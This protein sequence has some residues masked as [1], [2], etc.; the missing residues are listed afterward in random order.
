MIGTLIEKA[1]PLSNISGLRPIQSANS[2][3]NRVEK[4]LPRSTA[5]TMI[6]IW[7]RFR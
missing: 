5:A 4:T 7:P 3:A 2:P 6:E 1:T